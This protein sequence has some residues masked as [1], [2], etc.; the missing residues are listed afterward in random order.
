MYLLDFEVITK[1]DI[2]L[3]PRQAWGCVLGIHRLRLV[4]IQEHTFLGA[5]LGRVFLRNYKKSPFG[6]FFYII[7]SL[8]QQAHIP[9]L[10]LL[11]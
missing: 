9:L 7:Q 4:N 8:Y 2:V 10:L 3:C 11:T 1:V 6:D 5:G